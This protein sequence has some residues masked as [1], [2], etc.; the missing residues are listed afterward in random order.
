MNAAL[1]RVAGALLGL[2]RGAD[3]SAFYRGIYRAKVVK[4]HANRKRVDVEPEDELLPDM[5]NIPLKVGVPGLDP[6]LVPGH[7]VLVGWENGRPDRP[8]ATAWDAGVGVSGTTP[9]AL[10]FMGDLI[11]L[12]GR[13]SA[14]DPFATEAMP[15]FESY[16]RREIVRDT[17][18][19]TWITAVSAA[20]AADSSVPG[21][22]KG[23]VA[24]ALPV[25]TNAQNDLGAFDWFS[26]KVRNA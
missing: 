14:E 17:L 1:D 9:A 5:S 24:A 3:P 2:A 10:A 7:M 20:I 6:A 11:E 13:V 16:R 4:Q 12:G 26:T 25:L 15:K 8:Y 21:P 18:L 23:P 22:L 19:L